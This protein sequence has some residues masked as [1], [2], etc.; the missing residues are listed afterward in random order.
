MMLK[1][2]CLV[3]NLDIVIQDLKKVV[4]KPFLNFINTEAHLHL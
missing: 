2:I 3:K 4:L 1:F